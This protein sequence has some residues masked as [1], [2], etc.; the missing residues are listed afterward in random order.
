M[1]RLDETGCR[2]G[3]HRTHLAGVS[4]SISSTQHVITDNENIVPCVEAS[5]ILPITKIIFHS[6]HLHLGETLE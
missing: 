5:V 4:P 3:G 1:W 6:G 2:G